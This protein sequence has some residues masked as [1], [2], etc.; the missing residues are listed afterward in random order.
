VRVY[1]DPARGDN[2]PAFRLT[3]KGRD[4]YILARDGAVLS[5][6]NGPSGW[7]YAHGWHII[8]FGTRANSRHLVSLDEAADGVDTGQGWVHD[9][10]HGTRRMW[11]GGGEPSSERLASLTR[12][13]PEPIVADEVD[14]ANPR[15]EDFDPRAA[16]EAGY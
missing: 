4:I 2:T 16:Q 8:G 5:R 9:L 3:T 6:T 13:E 10:D 12:I 7:D 14:Y 1:G 11:A 15:F